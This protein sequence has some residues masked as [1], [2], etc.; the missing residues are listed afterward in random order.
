ML[1][2]Q[3]MRMRWFLSDS[4]GFLLNTS[5]LLLLL[6]HL[7][8]NLKYIRWVFEQFTRWR[9]WPEV[10]DIWSLLWGRLSWRSWE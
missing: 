10:R 8:L 1:G 5:Y 7:E 4:R 6:S 3:H 9:C 2:Q